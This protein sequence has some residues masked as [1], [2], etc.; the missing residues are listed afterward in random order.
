MSTQL[1]KNFV[2][3]FFKDDES[4]NEITGLDRKN[5]NK[6]LR[7]I[8][9]IA[10]KYRADKG[11][12]PKAF[13]LMLEE[14]GPTFVK[15]GQ[16]LSM[17]S[18]ILPKRFTDELTSLRSDVSPLP[19]DLVLQTLQ[20]EYGRP[21]DEIFASIDEHPEGSASVAQVHRAKLVTGE[22]VAIKV[23]RP[24]VQETM[25]QDISIMR[26]LVNTISF[27]TKQAQ[28]IDLNEVVEELWIT[29]QEETDFI[30]EAQNLVKFAEMNKD[31]VYIT[32]PKAYPELTT[33]HVI[34]MEYI[35]GINISQTE[36]LEK[37]GYDLKEIGLKLVDNYTTQVLEHGYFHGDPHPGNIFIR[38]GQIVYIDLGM[39]GY[40]SK[41]D[42][43]YLKAIMY[44]AGE[45]N[46]PALKEAL[47]NFAIEKDM[48]KVN[49][50]QFLADLDSIMSQFVSM[51]LRELDVGA[52]LNEL[53]SLAARSHVVM[54]SSASMISKGFVTLEGVLDENIP[55]TNLIQIITAHIVNEESKGE[56]A[57][58]EINEFLAK[59][60]LATRGLLN[61]ATFVPEFMK[62]MTRGQLE[63]N[64]NLGMEPSQL[65]KMSNM[66]DRLAL[67]V[68]I[69][70]L[71]IGSSIVYYA[72]I[73]PLIFGIPILGFL[74][75]LGAFIL[76]VIVVL[77]ILLTRKRMR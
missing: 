71:F 40:I 29:F 32:C 53:F 22:D 67:A 60:N 75:Y 64:M 2:A 37:R 46:V 30:Q 38:G 23:Q 44:A 41:R 10:K 9:K 13:R 18:E 48:A 21:L 51:N 50:A 52:F 39:M 62:M 49:H 68:I 11:L 54:P 57:Q 7:E 77:D 45:Q 59:S 73:K 70:G 47:L 76:S 26:T 12:T 65:S 27:A 35:D 19:Y 4:D 5:R 6:R 42:A 63:F 74:G 3:R 66:A 69:A 72:K 61:A 20:Q 33:K 24:G 16:V 14:L 36:E 56:K 25:A 43:N 58:R 34:V 17:R 15:A 55:N 8:M 31:V 28:I 1:G